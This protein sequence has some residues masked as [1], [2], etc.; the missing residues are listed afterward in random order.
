MEECYYYFLMLVLL[1]SIIFAG[2]VFFA[3]VAFFLLPLVPFSKEFETGK[4]GK[5]MQ[6]AKKLP[7][8]FLCYLPLTGALFGFA[9]FTT[10]L[11][12][13]LHNFNVES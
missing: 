3:G 10:F 11:D 13:R 5:E 1:I 6:I 2:V 12:G 8:E 9:T 4:I 7:I